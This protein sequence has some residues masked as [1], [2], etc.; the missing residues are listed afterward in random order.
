MLLLHE[1][2]ASTILFGSGGIEYPLKHLRNASNPPTA[3]DLKWVDLIVPALSSNPTAVPE[4][5]QH[6][7]LWNDLGLWRRIMQ[8]ATVDLKSPSILFEGWTRFS[9]DPVR[10][11]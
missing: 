7:N 4:M 2:S 10:F 1:D 9:F 5:V 11:E 6:A 8:S 3:R